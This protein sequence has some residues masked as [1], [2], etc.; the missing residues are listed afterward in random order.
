MFPVIM[1]VIIVKV[2]GIETSAT[3][4]EIT[5]AWRTLSLEFHPDKVK[6][7]GQRKEAQ[8]RFMEIQE[9][10]ELLSKRKLRRKSKNSK[11]A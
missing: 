5:A 10:Y 2:L 8:A 11:S 7:D 6:E 1:W 9:A 3:Q 4:A